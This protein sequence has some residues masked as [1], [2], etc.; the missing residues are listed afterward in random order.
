MPDNLIGAPG[1]HLYP[2]SLPHQWTETLDSRTRHQYR[3]QVAGRYLSRFLP[4][5]YS[6]PR[7]LQ[8]WQ[9]CTRRRHFPESEG[10]E[11]YCV[12]IAA[13][14]FLGG[15]AVNCTVFYEFQNSIKGENGVSLRHV[16]RWYLGC[17]C[18]DF[19]SQIMSKILNTCCSNAVVRKIIHS[20]GTI[21]IVSFLGWC[22]HKNS[23]FDFIHSL[24]T[25]NR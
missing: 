15:Q 4:L 1:A 23:L 7:S 19:L 11:P 10:K 9:S 14:V 21:I 20:G 22:V 8:R 2:R 17:T 24:T 5:V 18:P 13:D 12:N 25:T 6:A 3:E 16:F